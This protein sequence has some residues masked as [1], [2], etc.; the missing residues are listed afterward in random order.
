MSQVYLLEL[1]FTS[2][3]SWFCFYI[4]AINV[5]LSYIVNIALKYTNSHFAEICS[6]IFPHQYKM[7]EINYKIIK[8]QLVSLETIYKMILETLPCYVPFVCGN[9][10]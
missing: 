8:H 9:A 5:D 2:P 7:T 4:T 6:S 3:I 10:G 1:Q